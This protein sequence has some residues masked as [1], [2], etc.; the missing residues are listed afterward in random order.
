M[1]YLPGSTNYKPGWAVHHFS[2]GISCWRCNVWNAEKSQVLEGFWAQ[3]DKIFAFKGC[4]PYWP[5]CLVSQTTNWVGSL[6]F[7]L[8]NLV[9]AMKC[10]E[11]REILG[12][13]E[14]LGTEKFTL[15]PCKEHVLCSILPDLPPGY[16]FLMVIG[17]FHYFIKLID[18]SNACDFCFQD[19]TCPFTFIPQKICEIFL[20][21]CLHSHFCHVFT[22]FLHHRQHRLPV[23]WNPLGS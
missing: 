23:M 7:H 16:C 18:I 13:S 2:S 3:Q 19:K 17:S 6:L 12:P 22:Y 5:A 21:C 1:T 9:L 14:V 4:W 15:L 20:V 10:F 11:S 8:W